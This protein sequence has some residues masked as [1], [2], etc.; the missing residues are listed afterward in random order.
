VE[1]RVGVVRLVADLV[2]ALARTMN[3]A[4]EHDAALRLTERLEKLM[5]QREEVSR[6]DATRALEE[7]ADRLQRLLL[8]VGDVADTLAVVDEEEV[9]RHRIALQ[10]EVVVSLEALGV[11]AEAQLVRARIGR[12]PEHDQPVDYLFVQ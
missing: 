11:G 1:R 3:D 2:E 6:A 4:H 10:E 8:P 7:L 9:V 12:R 5:R